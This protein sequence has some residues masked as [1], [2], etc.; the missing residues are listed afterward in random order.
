MKYNYPPGPKSGLT[1]IGPMRRLMGDMIGQVLEL[2]REYGPA[3]SFR[4]GP[5]RV[6]LFSSPEAFAEV[7]QTKSTSFQ[8]P[9][10][11]K[12]I[13]SRWNGASLVL[14]DGDTWSRQRRLVAAAMPA[15]LVQGLPPLIVRRTRDRFPAEQ[16]HEVNLIAELER[17]TF[18][19]TAEAVLSRDYAALEETLFDTYTTIHEVALLELRGL[20]MLPD[21]APIAPKRR[22]QRALIHYKQVLRDAAQRR[23]AD[24]SY[25][26][27]FSRLLKLPDRAGDGAPMSQE[28]ARDEAGSLIFAGKETP[29]A[30]FMWT[31]YLLATHEDIQHRVHKEIDRVLAGRNATAEDIPQ[32][33]YTLQVLKEGMR[34]YPAAYIVTREAKEHVRIGDYDIRKR[35][36]VMLATYAMHH[37][38]SYFVDPE[39]FNPDRFTPE[40]EAALTPG[41]YAPFGVGRRECVGGEFALVEGVAIIATLLARFEI[42]LAPGQGTPEFDPL[43]ALYPK[44]GLQV[45]FT[46]RSPIVDRSM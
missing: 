7:L 24:D 27:I 39:R 44:G 42:R 34:Y 38:E 33:A 21:W 8:K 46:P 35:G 41:A 28:F 40:A 11:W 25:H 19:I 12:R 3:V 10:W 14:N 15:E 16:S 6:Y 17:L 2:K 23:L 29:A 13:F 43:V 32:L 18:D 5:T 30:A 31:L 45:R 20:S 9:K 1:G 22:M 36:Q 26:D 4:V 37:D